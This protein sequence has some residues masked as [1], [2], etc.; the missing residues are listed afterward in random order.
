M[1][2]IASLN[3]ASGF[4]IIGA[5]NTDLAGSS[6]GSVGDFNGDGISDIIVGAPESD[7][8]GNNMG[9]AHVLFGRRSG[10]PPQIN[11][12]N[13]N[14]TNGFTFLGSNAGE[15]AG[16]SVAGIGDINRDG[17]ADISVGAPFYGD[18]GS[19]DGRAY[20][21]FGK[22]GV[23]PM[24]RILG[25]G[26]SAAFLDVDGDEIVAKVTGGKVNADM[27]TFDG[28]GNLL[29]V[30]LNAGG[31]LK[32]GANISF[33][34]T[35]RGGDGLLNIGAISG[36]G[37]NLGKI[38]VT[39]DLGQI[40]ITPLNPL[41]PALKQLVVGSLG[42]MG[43]VNQIP[44]TVDPLLSEIGGSVTKVIVKRNVQFA[45]LFI[46][47]SLG[48][49]TVNGEFNGLGALNSTQLAALGLATADVAGGSTLANSGLSAG[50]IG[51]LNIKQSLN[52][53]AVQSGGNIGS[54]SVG[55]SVN[56]GA[57]V[58]GGNIG[59]VK[60]VNSITSDDINSPSVI[61]ARGRLN[62]SNAAAAVAINVFTVRGD[63][64]N[65][66]ILIGYDSS[67]AAV[68]PDAG[69]G[70]L[71]VRG[72]WTASSLTAGIADGGDDGF[73]RNDIAI[74]EAVADTILARIASIV[75][76]G[77]VSGSAA[78]DDSFAIT[79]ERISKAKIGTTVL[80]LDKAVFDDILVDAT[81]DFRI[82]EIAR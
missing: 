4:E 15:Q 54:A 18:D 38:S 11:V 49:I 59:V 40:D 3:G 62:P 10:I 13:I 75:I 77:T 25:G 45:S 26:T 60:V 36:V 5:A 16:F 22:A 51:Q 9:A 30:D 6:V 65:A 73:G 78:G 8:S 63:V 12:V 74:P 57:I 58:A 61:A 19:V 43:E 56:R 1:V 27:F 33:F 14:G 17:F 48:N 21:V 34:V 39:G 37:L 32:R 41:K 50:S 81:D 52:N 68:N 35:P 69:L 82:K 28:D 7:A 64:T 29:F 31:T 70:K 80:P 71:T 23:R 2:D 76:V 55:G 46:E 53:A 79:A 24:P 47:G 42:M 44:G 66:E 72:N 20:V 67:F